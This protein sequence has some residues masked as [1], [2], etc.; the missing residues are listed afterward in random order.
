M[1]TIAYADP[2]TVNIIINSTC[3]DIVSSSMV[4]LA[5]ETMVSMFNGYI[6]QLQQVASTSSQE[7]FRA[8]FVIKSCG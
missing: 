5:E 4:N 2:Q 3:I 6:E 7:L 8:P 1:V